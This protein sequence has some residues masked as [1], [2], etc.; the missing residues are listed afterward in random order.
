MGSNGSPLRT[1]RENLD[2]DPPV[3][4]TDPY[5]Y[6]YRYIWGTGLGIAEKRSRYVLTRK[7]QPYEYINH[8]YNFRHTLLL[9][10]DRFNFLSN[11]K[12]NPLYFF[13]NIIV[14]S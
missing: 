12:I 7:M 13:K 4:R 10:C 5:I 2:S 14:T 6:R 8:R 3:P 9:L 11:Q 1:G